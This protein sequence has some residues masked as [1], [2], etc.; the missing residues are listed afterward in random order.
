MTNIMGSI[1]NSRI[2]FVYLPSNNLEEGAPYEKV[3]TY[4]DSR[5]DGCELTST[6]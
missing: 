6:R 2:N 1:W 3:T 5:S 4:D